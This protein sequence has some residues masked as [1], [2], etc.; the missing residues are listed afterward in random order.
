MGWAPPRLAGSFGL[1]TTVLW[2]LWVYVVGVTIDMAPADEEVEPKSG[3]GVAVLAAR[4]TIVKMGYPLRATSS[5][6]TDGCH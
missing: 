4:P 5:S 3:E 6:P 2:P 1:Q